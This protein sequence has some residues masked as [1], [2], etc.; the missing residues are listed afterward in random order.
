MD[1]V[2]LIEQLK[3]YLANLVRRKFLDVVREPIEIRMTL[4]NK[5][6]QDIDL[7][8]TVECIEQGFDSRSWVKLIQLFDPGL[9]LRKIA[10][11]D[12]DA[13]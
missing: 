12:F 4:F 9:N 5:G 8:L 13:R 11:R 2:Q 3:G 6:I 7:F 10:K 1:V